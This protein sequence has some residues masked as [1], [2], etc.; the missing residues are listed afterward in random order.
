MWLAAGIMSVVFCVIA[1]AMSV[2]KNEKAC[3][4]SAC[5]L[6]FVAISLLME[7]RLILNWV[8]KNDW[9]AL[10]DVIPSMY[11]FFCRYVIIMLILNAAVIVLNTRQQKIPSAK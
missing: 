8:S 7:Y 3:W 10:M 11:G 2:M 6:S 1:L 9:S 4:A 5:S